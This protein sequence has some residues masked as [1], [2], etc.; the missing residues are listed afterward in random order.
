VIYHARV[1]REAHGFSCVFPDLSK[2]GVCVTEGDTLAE[3]RRN[4]DEALSGF[5]E[6][7]LDHGGVIPLPRHRRGGKGWL[8]VAVDAELAVPIILRYVR[9][10]QAASPEEM[11]RRLAL[12]LKAYRRLERSLGAR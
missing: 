2:V 5:V 11:A 10:R 4:A 8:A 9:D 7:V 12:P 1:R 3:L 6:T